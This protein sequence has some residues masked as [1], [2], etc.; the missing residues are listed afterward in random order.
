MT[1][2]RIDGTVRITLDDIEAEE[3]LDFLG[4]FFEETEAV[5]DRLY[6]ALYTAMEG[7]EGDV[8]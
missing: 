8:S 2:D 3:F 1:I 5:S 4:Q 6:A 7:E